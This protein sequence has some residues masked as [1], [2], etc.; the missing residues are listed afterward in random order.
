MN[1]ALAQELETCQH[2]ALLYVIADSADPNGVTRHCD[3]D[4]MASKARLSRATMFRRLS[5][6]E[7][8]K[9]L[10]RRKYYTEAGTPRYEIKLDLDLR[11]SL[12]LRSRRKGDEDDPDG[13][14]AEI[15][16]SQAE[17]LAGAESHGSETGAVSPVRPAQSHSC[18]SISPTLSKELPP[19]PPPGGFR[20]KREV[21]RSEERE[22]VWRAFLGVYPGISA[23]P[24]DDARNALD[25]LPIDETEW[26]ISSAP[27]YAAECRKLS[28]AP[29]NAHTWLRKAMFKNFPRG[30]PP[31]ARPDS[32]AADSPEGR[33]LA[34]LHQVA[35]KTIPTINGRVTYRGEV[36]P[37][38]L[39]F[40]QAGERSAWPWIESSDA[41]RDQIAAWARFI[42]AHVPGP[43]GPLIE[44]RGLGANQRAGIHA[45][46]PWP[47]KKDGSIYQ[48][49]VPEEPDHA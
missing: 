41:T 26:A 14:N 10:S 12:P 18:D 23:M 17:T 3:P 4:Y 5:E 16:K 22:A 1:W 38:L 44:T 49:P 48:N 37:Q 32:F 31:P 20:S 35:R 6:L 19:N 24:Q 7:D 9:V 36:T 33:A 43:R 11:I 25:A 13:E 8:L 30:G 47:P 46:W 42:E 34:A 28:K 40:A 15:P 21:E 29:K 45:P 27:L 2:Q 39:A